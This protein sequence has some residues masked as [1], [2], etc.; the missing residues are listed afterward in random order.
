[1]ILVVFWVIDCL[2][3]NPFVPGCFVISSSRWKP[4]DTHCNALKSSTSQSSCH[5]HISQQNPS[6][7]IFRLNKELLDF[8]STS[9]A[10]WDD[11]ELPNS[12]TIFLTTAHT[13]KLTILQRH[14]TYCPR[15][16][17]ILGTK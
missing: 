16:P 11:W 10:I 8:T 6:T 5:P 15:F 14:W 12:K 13:Q 3:Q 9:T 7:C 1:L 4:P 2:E 17:P